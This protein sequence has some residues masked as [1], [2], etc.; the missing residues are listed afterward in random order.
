MNDA[1]H[2][3]TNWEPYCVDLSNTWRIS[4]DINPVW[5]S[6]LHNLDCAKSYGR[7]SQPGAW[8]DLDLME[9]DIG[10]FEYS[11]FHPTGSG[12]AEQ[13]AHRLLMNEAHFAIWSILSAPLIVGMDLRNV[14]TEI[15][16]LVT[17]ELAVAVNQNYLDHGGDV[18]TEFDIT[19]RLQREGGHFI[20]LSDCKSV[21]Y[22]SD[23]AH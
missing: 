13:R 20:M 22:S 10:S 1:K 12:S 14:S 23:E 2:R 19:D 11:T 6:I 21:R 4:T 8:T 5:K 7:W 16:D 9:I 18:I 3:R 17:N 15:V